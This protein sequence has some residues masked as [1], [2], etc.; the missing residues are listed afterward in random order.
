M[1]LLII[2]L[3]L[4]SSVPPITLFF[5][6]KWIYKDNWKYGWHLFYFFKYLFALSFL[7]LLFLNNLN[8]GLKPTSTLSM[9]FLILTIFLALLGIRPAIKEKVLYFY[10]G[11]VYAAFMEEILYRSIIFG[12]VFGIG[13]N[14]W[15]ALGASSFLFGCWHLKNYHWVNKPSIIN[16][17]FYTAFIYGPIFCLLRIYTGDI[18]LAVLFHYITDA[19]CA[20][21]PQWMRN[22]GLVQGGRGG[23]YMDDYKLKE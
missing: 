10:L 16:Q 21:A 19:T 14:Q 23:K 7:P 17:F 2:L 15:I 12:L 1:F 13:Q 6:L 20:L 18:Y 3:I 9:V 8:L 4:Y 5:C 22:G 11:G